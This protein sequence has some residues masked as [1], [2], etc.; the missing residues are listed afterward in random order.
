M[1]T[2]AIVVDKSELIINCFERKE[3]NENSKVVKYSN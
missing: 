1:H 2:M 3:T